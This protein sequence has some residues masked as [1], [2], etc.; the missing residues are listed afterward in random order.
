MIEFFLLFI[1]IILI[2]FF[3]KKNNFLL[4][5]TGQIH[6][7]YSQKNQVPLSGGLFIL[8]YFF[9]SYELFDLNLII[10]LTIFFLLGLLA[11]LNLVQSPFLRFFSQIILIIIFL[12][13]LGLNIHDV[14]IDLV[15]SFL[16][17]Y[18]FNVFFLSFCFLVLIN[19]SNFIDGNNGIC[20]GY[21]LIIFIIIFN[22]INQ[23]I[24]LYD[25]T[26]IKSFIVLLNILLLFNLF[27]KIYLGD[28]GVYLL[29]LITGYLLINI[30]NQNQNLS[31]YF[32]ANLFW[33]PA[34][35]ML[36]SLIRKIRIKYSP[37]KPDTMHFHQLL[38]FYFTKKISL[39]KNII[40]SITGLSINFFNVFI[41]YFSSI[42]FNNTKIQILF[43]F[44]SSCVYVI[45][46][47]ILLKFK[48]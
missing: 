47:I 24:I 48:K 31:P 32:I 34:F 16:K 10:F 6:Q 20:L 30:I 44:F 36:F 41:L 37:L 25:E 5:N 38:F 1:L 40:N 27:N 18:Y 29:S 28:S 13:N 9:Y 7:T 14:R 11:D 4:N 22:L 17:N 15:N 3:L 35:E 19:G 12:I 23:R 43:L 26:F 39:N 21:F 8:I 45:F 46:Y 42:Y 2:N 33:Y